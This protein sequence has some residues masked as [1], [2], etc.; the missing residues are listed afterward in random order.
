IEK[1]EAMMKKLAPQ[2]LRGCKIRPTYFEPTFHKFK[3][4][5]CNGLQVFTESPFY[6]PIHFTPYRLCHVFLKA[7]KHVHHDFDLWRKPPYEY[8]ENLMP[9]D[10]LSGNTKLREWVEDSSP[11]V[12]E[13]DEYMKDDEAKWIEE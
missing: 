3:G 9:I 2:W 10:I 5:L 1:I 11:K 13:W 8:E 6:D 12:D 7:V 4:Q